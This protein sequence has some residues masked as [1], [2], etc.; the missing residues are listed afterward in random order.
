MLWYSR[1][2]AVEFADFIRDLTNESPSPHIVEIHPPFYDYTDLK[3]FMDNYRVFEERI[4]AYFPDT[5]VLLENRCGT[6]YS[7][8]K[9]VVSTIDQL[10]KLSALIDHLQVDLRFTVDIPQLLSQKN[11]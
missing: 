4:S 11:G 10:I 8:G 7:G 5:I 2:W 6:L 1:K 9:F 3:G